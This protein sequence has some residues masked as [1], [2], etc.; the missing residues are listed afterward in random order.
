MPHLHNA[1]TV[2]TGSQVALFI[3]DFTGKT[4]LDVSCMKKDLIVSTA[5]K[6]GS[7]ANLN[8]FFTFLD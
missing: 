8:L 1:A 7:P 3:V 6:K 2:E 5:Q 4:P